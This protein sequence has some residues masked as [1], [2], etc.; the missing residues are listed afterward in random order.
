MCGI[1]FSQNDNKIDN[2]DPL[3]KRGPDGFSEIH[4]DLGYFAF[5]LLNT[6]GE[7]T[8]HFILEKSAFI[9]G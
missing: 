1:L 6:I 2:L 4:N 8:A 3:K 7:S 5:S 9:S